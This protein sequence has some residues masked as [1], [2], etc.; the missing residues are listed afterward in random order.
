[1]YNFGPTLYS[2]GAGERCGPMKPKLIFPLAGVIE[3]AP[4][5]DCAAS[6]VLLHL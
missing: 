2:E 5:V 4:A 6:Q 1:M 3:Q